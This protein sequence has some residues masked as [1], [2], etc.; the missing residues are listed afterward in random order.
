[1]KKFFALVL[2]LSLGMM[3]GCGDEPKKGSGSGRT[4]TSAGNTI[5]TATTS[6]GSS[7]H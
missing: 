1:M 5:I 3:V 7:S 6:S 2:L 4:T